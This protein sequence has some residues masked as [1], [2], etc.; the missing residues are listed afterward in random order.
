MVAG[1]ALVRP[2]II[3]YC[4]A[5]KRSAR[6][7]REDWDLLICTECLQ[8]REHL[9]ALAHVFGLIAKVNAF[10]LANGWTPPGGNSR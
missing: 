2:P 9:D 6:C 7:W 5:C 4:Y 1:G 8:G 10:Y 3:G